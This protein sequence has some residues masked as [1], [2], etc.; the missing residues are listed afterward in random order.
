MHRGVLDLVDCPHEGRAGGRDFGH[1]CED[2]R[3]GGQR[4]RTSWRRETNAQTPIQKKNEHTPR[5]SAVTSPTDASSRADARARRWHQ[6]GACEWDARVPLPNAIRPSP[7]SRRGGP[8]PTLGGTLAR[9]RSTRGGS[10]DT[11]GTAGP[12]AGPRARW[13][14]RERPLCAKR[15]HAPC[16]PKSGSHG[17]T[18]VVISRRDDVQRRGPW[19]VLTRDTGVP[20]Y[21]SGSRRS[22]ASQHRQSHFFDREVF[23]ANRSSTNSLPKSEARRVG[24]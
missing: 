13:L 4:R 14:V 15:R 12:A 11:R 22:W 7:A 8:H 6:R 2:G 9:W 19:F 20:N 10:A 3:R 23:F 21:T 5:L 16:P 17:R 18:C 24:E 1:H